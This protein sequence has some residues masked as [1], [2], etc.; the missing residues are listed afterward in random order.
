M[1]RSESQIKVKAERSVVCRLSRELTPDEEARFDEFTGEGPHASYMQKTS[2]VNLAP[3]QLLRSFLFITCEERGSLI[4]AGLARLAGLYRGRYLAKFQRGPVFKDTALL[5]RA[6]PHV[7]AA[8]REAGACTAVMNPRWQDGGA[9]EVEAVFAS[10]GMRKLPERDQSM[11]TATALVDLEPS[12]DEI[13][14]RFER[15]CR[16]DIRRGVKKGVTVRPAATEDEARL[17]RGRRRELAALRD[18]EDLGQPDLVDQ[19]RSFQENGDGS[20]L[21][22]EAQGQVLAG[23]AVATEGSR[24]VAR[25]GGGPPIL[26]AV[27]RMHNLIW[28]AMREFK[29]RG[30]IT[31]D[32]AGVLDGK[33]SDKAGE[34]RDFFKMSFNPKIVRLVPMYCAA[35]RPVDHAVFFR[36]WRWYRRTPLKKILGPAFRRG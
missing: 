12:E 30:C 2:W 35:L 25:S 32:L 21:L 26:P 9:E 10:H 27:P 15:R 20:L 14:A 16:K 3:S 8:L 28:E 18:F 19:W 11:Y 31:F 13:F 22:A 23:L 29:A 34:R 7:L 4:L 5:D 36:A 1:P 24:A 33:S 17:V 6:L